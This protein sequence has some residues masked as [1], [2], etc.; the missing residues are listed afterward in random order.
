MVAHLHLASFILSG[1]VNPSEYYQSEVGSALAISF[2]P[3]STASNLPRWVGE[4]RGVCTAAPCL[5]PLQT[6]R[7]DKYSPP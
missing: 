1:C 2:Y 5:P 4:D 3:L 6:R 7:M